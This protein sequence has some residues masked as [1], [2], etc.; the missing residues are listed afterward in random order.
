ME[1]ETVRKAWFLR[2][3]VGAKKSSEVGGC[4]FKKKKKR[5]GNPTSQVCRKKINEVCLSPGQSPSPRPAREECDPGAASSRRRGSGD[6]ERD[7][8]PARTGPAWPV[9]AVSARADAQDCGRREAPTAQ[10]GPSASSLIQGWP[11]PPPQCIL[12]PLQ[13]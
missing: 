7:P 5:G 3:K 9:P 10:R 8:P 2:R 12:P 6:R 1:R 4:V 11:P 13:A